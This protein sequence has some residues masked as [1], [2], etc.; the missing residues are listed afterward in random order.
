MKLDEFYDL[1]RQF[2]IIGLT[3]RQS[4]GSTIIANLL[5]K[6]SN[7]FK[8]E[9]KSDIQESVNFDILKQKICNRFILSQSDI[10][11]TTINYRDILLLLLFKE[12][13]YKNH[14]EVGIELLNNLITSLG[15]F[16][17]DGQLKKK[18]HQRLCSNEHKVLFDE[19]THFIKKNQAIVQYLSNH[20]LSKKEDYLNKGFY[21][22]YFTRFQS[23]TLNFIDL[24]NKYDYSLRNLFFHDLATTIRLH[25]KVEKCATSMGSNNVYSVVTV[26]NWVLKSHRN[27]SIQNNTRYVIDSLKNSL[28]LTYFKEKYSAFFML[29]VNTFEDERIKNIFNKVDDF[30]KNDSAKSIKIKELLLKLDDTE[31]KSKE[32]NSGFFASPDVENCI[33]KCDYHIFYS[34]KFKGTLDDSIS[35]GSEKLEIDTNYLTLNK[36]T[37]LS[38]FISLIFNP[39]IVTPTIIERTMQIAFTAKLSSGCISRQ[40]GAVVT[41][42]NYSTKAIGWNDV[43]ENQMPCNLRD[44]RDLRDGKNLD[45]FS[46]FEKNDGQLKTLNYGDGLSFKEKIVD[47]YS[48]HSNLD[49][50]LS[51]KSC[52]FCF[53]SCH[54]DF[55]EK[56]NQVHTRSLHA[57]ENAML[58]ISKYG[59][60]ALHSGYLFTTAS[61]CE[62]CA[63]KAFQLGLTKIYY[64][65]PYPGISRFHTLMNGISS[66]MN[67]SLIM[68]Q[69]AIGRGFLRLYQPFMAIKD[70]LSIMTNVKFELSSKK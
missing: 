49:S 62:L 65:D 34:N 46:E 3:G 20:D 14:E 70:E 12:A 36:Q 35:K 53:K 38:K 33:Q 7:L 22:F 58:Q 43:A 55:E 54:N 26:L 9:L 63:K 64:I 69:G 45:H 24:I 42:K 68:F 21:E 28:E 66:S 56:E 16:Y 52:S 37:Q 60:A 15:T 17:E 57:E 10:A 19:I 31:Y 40:V 67:P 30:H 11:Y 32:V 6:D 39:G 25:G 29:S 59:G 5:Q 8:E 4:S 50:L 27:N 47:R 23:F 41:D 18:N 48:V 1:R 2:S 61:P 13:F 51:G 44:F